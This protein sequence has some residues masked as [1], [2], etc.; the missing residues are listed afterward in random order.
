MKAWYSSKTLWFNVIMTLVMGIPV[1]ASAYKAMSPE[2]AVLADAIAG[3]ITGLGNIFIRVWFTE[4][5][6]ENPFR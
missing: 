1:I 5:K 4:E 6:I 2:Q 3:L